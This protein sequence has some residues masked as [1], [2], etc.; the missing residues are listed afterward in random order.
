MTDMT[1]PR[2]AG[3]AS[4]AGTSFSSRNAPQVSRHPKIAS[5]K[6][7][8]ESLPQC[9]AACRDGRELLLDS[10]GFPMFQRAGQASPRDP[11]MPL[12]TLS[13]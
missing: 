2:R 13:A 9:I 3:Y 12:S 4:E 8:A 7:G 11:L 10:R 1:R 6:V 5:L